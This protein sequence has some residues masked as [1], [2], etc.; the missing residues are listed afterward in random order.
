[1]MFGGSSPWRW[2]STAP[3][4]SGP[5]CPQSFEPGSR[6]GWSAGSGRECPPADLADVHYAEHRLRRWLG[7]VRH[8]VAHN[9]VADP[10]QLNAG[11]RTALAMGHEL[12]RV[13]VIPFELIR[14]LC[15]PLARVPLAGKGGT[16]RR[17]Q[18]L[19]TPIATTFHR[20]PVAVVAVTAGRTSGFPRWFR[21]SP[22]S[23]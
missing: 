5:R 16:R 3:G 2:G 22:P 15:E 19:P 6:V 20:L 14:R 23:C 1:M 7:A 12:R 10:L 21:C 9:P 18:W 11:F 4:S 13:D 17:G 8:V